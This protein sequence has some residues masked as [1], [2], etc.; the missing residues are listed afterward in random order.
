[1]AALLLAPA[2]S[3]IAGTQRI[4]A[5]DEDP[6][7]TLARLEK[8]AEALNKEYRGE[9]ITLSDV[10]NDAR[11][12]IARAD[13]LNSQLRSSSERVKQL[14]ALSYMGGGL[15]PTMAV[16]DPDP[17]GT[18]KDMALMAFVR[19]TDGTR[20][21]ELEALAAQADQARKSTQGKIAEVQ[22]TVNELI[23]KR[24][25]VRTL[26]AKYEP[27]VATTQDVTSRPEVADS[28]GG[29]DSP[30]SPSGPS[31]PDNAPKGKSPLI[32]NTMTARMRTLYLEI[33]Q[34]FGPFPAIGCARPG[35]PLDHGS[36]RACDFMESAG[37]RMPSARAQAHGDAVAQYVIDNASRL[38]LKYVIW[39]QRIWDVRSGNGW[40]A[41][42]DR[43]GV[44][45]NHFD[46]N[47]VSVL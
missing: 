44:T 19:Q 25:A 46:H 30:S 5:P 20:V 28:P 16:T 40:K 17:T 27:E 18:I 29:A 37:G 32:G 31:K 45:A 22:E 24:S 8:Q 12:A 34:K 15:D 13:G 23:R 41:M 38:G 7:T 6:K 33:D 35:D 4:A 9:V 36:G 39:K 2:G 42:S 47:H 26:L 3:G 43:G 21:S 14:A 11:K 10:R 1:M